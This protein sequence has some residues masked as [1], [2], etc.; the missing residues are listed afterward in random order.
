MKNEKGKVFERLVARTP[1]FGVA[2]TPE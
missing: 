1:E 2:R